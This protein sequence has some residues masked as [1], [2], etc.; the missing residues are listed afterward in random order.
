MLLVQ[1]HLSS[2]GM[3]YALLVPNQ[4]RNHNGLSQLNM[5]GITCFTEFRR[6]LVQHGRLWKQ[7]CNVE[8]CHGKWEF[9]EKKTDVT[10]KLGVSKRYRLYYILIIY[11][12]VQW[13][14]NYLIPCWFLYTCP[15]TKKWSVYNFN[16]RFIW[17]VT[18]RTTTTKNI[19]KN[20]FLK[21]L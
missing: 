7:V 4:E 18:D 11:M 20:A 9:E 15:L 17:T 10:E 3:K 13:G 12:Y 5:L 8:L 2:R 21:K 16:G 1:M 19:Q 6:R 14:K